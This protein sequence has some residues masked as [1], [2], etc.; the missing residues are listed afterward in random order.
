MQ[1][2]TLP[3]NWD[4]RDVN[5]QNY[6]SYSRNQHV[7]Q[8]C[9]SCWAHAASSALADRINIMKNNSFP[10][11]ALSVQALINCMAGGACF[12]G[13]PSGV[14]EFG[15]TDG[16]PEDSCQNYMAADPDDFACSPMQRCKDCRA[17]SIVKGDPNG[18]KN[19]WAVSYKPWYVTEY[20]TVSGVHRM[21]AEIYRRGP[22]A[23]GIEATDAFE[24]Y[25]GGIY[26]EKKEFASIN[27]EISVVGWGFDEESG[28]EYW[29]GRN[30]WGSY[31]GEYGFFRIKMHSDN[32]GIEEYCDWAVPS[33]FKPEMAQ[34]FSRMK[35][36]YENN[37][38]P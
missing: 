8:Y 7:P 16:I 27:H 12:G 21:K 6:L 20:G 33:A 34:A 17:P 4:W 38:G 32:L 14:Y 28:T 22:I 11:V 31:W 2:G 13:D 15:F 18:D 19:C 23:C 25:T 35:Q 24:N 10:Q 5:G 26:S 1:V 36:I 37:K 29:I 9:G 3:D 30:S